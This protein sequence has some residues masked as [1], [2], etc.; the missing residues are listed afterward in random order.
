MGVNIFNPPAIIREHRQ[1]QS[2][3]QVLHSSNEDILVHAFF[4][5][6]NKYRGPDGRT[7]MY[8]DND[9]KY[10]STRVSPYSPFIYDNIEPGVIDLIKVLHNKGYLTSDSCQGH[11][12]SHYRFVMLCFNTRDQ[13]EDFKQN[14]E[15]FNLPI[16]FQDNIINKDNSPSSIGYGLVYDQLS[17]TKRLDRK[18]FK[19]I[20]Y[21]YEDAVKYFNL[22][23]IRDYTEYHLLKVSIC[24]NL[25]YKERTFKRA[26][27][28]VYYFFLYKFF[29]DYY[30]RKLTD[31]VSKY[32]PEYADKI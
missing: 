21:S 4:K 19:M 8:I 23:F 2:N 13:L 20:P 24:S 30:T 29:R 18:D 25:T 9:G 16:Q 5:G 3:R 12:D 27:M 17:V 31:K 22:M 14:I 11:E 10:V 32:L 6:T 7:Y 28:A 1:E 26:Y 15:S